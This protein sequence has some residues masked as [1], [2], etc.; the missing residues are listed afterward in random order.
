MNKGPFWLTCRYELTADGD[1]LCDFSEAVIIA[2]PVSPEAERM[3]SHRESWVSVGGGRRVPWN[4][5]PRGRVEL[6]RGRVIV[7][8][9]PLCFACEAL[10]SGLR[11]KFG[12]PETVK[13][14]FKADDSAHYACAMNLPYLL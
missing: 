4:Y 14:T 1:V 13:M 7:F 10:E 8:A 6:R 12:I 3:L 5:Y 2:R 9:N 11:D